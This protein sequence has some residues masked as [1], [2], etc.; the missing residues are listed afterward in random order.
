LVLLAAQLSGWTDDTPAAPTV[1][2]SVTDT[3]VVDIAAGIAK[4]S[5]LAVVVTAG[6]EDAVSLQLDAVTVDEAVAKL[7]ESFEGSW[8]KGYIVET[9]APE[10]PYQAEQLIEVMQ[11][12]RDQWMESLQALPEEERRAIMSA[13]FAGRG[14]RGGRGMGPQGQGPQGWGPEGA[15]PQGQG[16]QGQGPQGEGPQPQVAQVEGPQAAPPQAGEQANAGPGG[17][18]G[19]GGP[20]QG[21]RRGMRDDPLRGLM[22][23]G[24]ENAVSIDLQGMPLGDAELQFFQAS[25]YILLAPKSLDGQITA[26]AQEAPIKDVLDQFAASL[27]AKWRTFYVLCKPRELSEA[28]VEERMEQRFQNGMAQLWQMSPEERSDRLTRMVERTNR[29]IERFQNVPPEQRQRMQSR[30]NRRFGR[31]TQYSATLTP[32]QRKE[33]KPLLRAMGQLIQQ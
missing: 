6:V 20:G 14:Q 32:E 30:M 27:D 4:Q 10:Q 23:R 21:G 17:G 11:A 1:T 33:L 3:K 5:E 9:A 15:G 22:Y 28:E 25:G 19:Q 24:R 7:A 16:Q 13:M 29:M 31:M 18:P 2:L 8:V 12:V 26:S